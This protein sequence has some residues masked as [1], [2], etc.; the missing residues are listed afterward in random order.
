MIDTTTDNRDPSTW[1]WA[2]PAQTPH[3][4][5]TA[6][7]AAMRYRISPDAIDC[8][9]WSPN[10]GARRYELESGI[11]QRGYDP[12]AGAY[13]LPDLADMRAAANRMR[14]AAASRPCRWCGG[15]LHAPRHNFGSGASAPHNY[16]PAPV[17]RIPDEDFGPVLNP[18]GTPT[19]FTVEML[20]GRKPDRTQEA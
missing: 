13:S 19:D 20:T 1:G 3:Y 11:G 18:D 6:E 14:Q 12:A 5:S 2:M 8:A 16:D 4:P 10:D 7:L 15:D 17:V 9:G